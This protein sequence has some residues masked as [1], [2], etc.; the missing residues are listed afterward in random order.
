MKHIILI[1]LTSLTLNVS[2]QQLISKNS[3]LLTVNTKLGYIVYFKGLSAEPDEYKEGNIYIYDV[4]KKVSSLLNSNVYILE[5]LRVDWTTNGDIFFI[6]TGDSLVGFSLNNKEKRNVYKTH[7]DGVINNFSISDNG[8][9]I[10]VNEKIFSTEG[11]KQITYLITNEST[12]PVVIYTINDPSEGEMLKNEL[13]VGTFGNKVF[14]RNIN[15]ELFEYDI[16]NLSLNKIDSNVIKA[17]CV[18]KENIYYTKQNS[19]TQFN[20][21]T[22]TY[23][24]ILEGEKLNIYYIGSYIDK[25]AICLNDNMFLYE[26]GIGLKRINNLKKGKYI[27]LDEEYAIED[28]DNSLYIHIPQ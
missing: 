26:E 18:S 28:L 4:N 1:I 8:K 16:E 22:N 10:V 7:K 11:S 25:L 23:F 2:C 17:Y 24:E 6:S 19:L 15:N 13:L 14:I 12:E 27:Y 5:F 20:T 21:N 9:I 3:W